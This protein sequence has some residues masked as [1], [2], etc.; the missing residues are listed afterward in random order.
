[1]QCK[2]LHETTQQPLPP[3][4]RLG[5]LHEHGDLPPQRL[6]VAHHV[7]V[8]GAEQVLHLGVVIP[9]LLPL[10]QLDVIPERDLAR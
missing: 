2:N 3:P 9:P 8:L 5:L 10:L 1:M 7:A 6:Q 4:M